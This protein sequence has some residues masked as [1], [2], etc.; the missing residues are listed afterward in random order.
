[1]ILKGSRGNTT[2]AQSFL[3]LFCKFNVGGRYVGS[4]YIIFGVSNG[5]QPR[6]YVEYLVQCVVE[7]RVYLHSSTYNM[8]KYHKTVD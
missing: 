5:N 2:Q 3:S 1:M 4:I 6:I 7:H 8:Q